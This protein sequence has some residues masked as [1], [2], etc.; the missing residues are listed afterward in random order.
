MRQRSASSALG[1]KA[2]GL[3]PTAGP[4]NP[5]ASHEKRK[6]PTGP[7]ELFLFPG[8]AKTFFFT[9]YIQK[10]FFF[11]SYIQNSRLEE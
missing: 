10:T 7:V 3:P 9:S 2:R 5:N 4:S 11:T 1:E 8:I 6:S